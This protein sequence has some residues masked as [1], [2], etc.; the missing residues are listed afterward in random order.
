M[1]K[2][3]ADELFVNLV[4]DDKDAV[5]QTDPGDAFE[6]RAPP[7]AADRVVRA[8]QDEEIDIVLDDF[9]FKIVKVDFVASVFEPER[10]V[11]ECAPVVADDVRKRIVDGLLDE[12]G[13]ARFGECADGGCDGKDDA[14]RD[15]E[16]AACDVPMMMCFEPVLQDGE[17]VVLYLRIAED[18]VRR[19][20]IEGVEDG[21]GRAKVH[22][23]DPERQN[24]LGIAA[25][26][27]EVVFEA[28]RMAG[29]DDFIKVEIFRGR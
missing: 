28:V 11:D 12:Y 6:L 26:N 9:L 22:V 4:R 3:G 17:V 18:A 14:R 27:G 21:R 5:P 2:T 1:R 29:L 19:A 7:H 20:A 23:G 13:I 10:V 15:H 24:V 25:L 16:L 8:A